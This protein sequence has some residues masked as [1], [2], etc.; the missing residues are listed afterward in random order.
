LRG[1]RQARVEAKGDVVWG[2]NVFKRAIVWVKDG[3][4]FPKGGVG[5]ASDQEP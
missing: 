1:Y 5:K 3:D 4:G 2:M